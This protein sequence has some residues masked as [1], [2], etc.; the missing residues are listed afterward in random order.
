M[1]NRRDLKEKAKDA[2]RGNYMNA[3]LVSLVILLTG[4]GHNSGGGSGGSSSQG[5]NEYISAWL[6]MII[7]LVVFIFILIRIFVGYAIEVGGRKY[8]VSLFTEADSETRLLG[9]GFKNKR[10]WDI[11]LT[12]LVRDIFLIGWFLLLII[13]GIIKSYS[14]RMTTY[15]LAENPNIGRTR[16]IELSKEMT[17]GEKLDIFVLDLSFIGWYI[18]GLLA[19]GIGILFVQPYYDATNAALYIRLREKAISNGLTTEDELT[20]RQLDFGEVY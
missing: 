13:P 17:R 9:Y 4:G 2:L 7:A 16:A 8:F 6:L 14:Y 19:L 11:L 5:M 12:L 10:Y 15:I 1:W 3:F 18:L 20:E